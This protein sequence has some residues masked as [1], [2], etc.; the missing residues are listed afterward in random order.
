[1][2]VITPRPALRA[3]GDQSH[4]TTAWQPSDDKADT[5]GAGLFFFL[6]PFA[7]APLR[8]A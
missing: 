8:R 7:V 2:N 6:F 4:R 1:L 5:L 3:G